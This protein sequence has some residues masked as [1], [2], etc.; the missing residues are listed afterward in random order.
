[1]LYQEIT[2][3]T[4]KTCQYS[5]LFQKLCNCH[6]NIITVN[7]SSP[8]AFGTRLL[9]PTHPHLPVPD[10][11]K[12]P[13]PPLHF[14]PPCTCSS[15]MVTSHNHRCSY[16]APLCI[17]VLNVF[18]TGTGDKA[19]RTSGWETNLVRA[20]DSLQKKSLISWDYQGKFAEK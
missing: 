9:T 12:S 6:Y 10:F 20:C 13:P 15:L 16:C 3:S 14:V 7:M 8:P 11:M 1:M 4:F 5:L 18:E 2:L 19:Q 17:P